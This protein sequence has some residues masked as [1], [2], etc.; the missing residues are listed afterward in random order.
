MAEETILEGKIE[1]KEKPK[2][3]FIELTNERILF[4][5]E[6]G[7]FKKRMMIFDELDLKKINKENKKAKITLEELKITIDAK[8]GLIEFNCKEEKIAKELVNN[9]HKL[10]DEPST[11]EK[12]KESIKNIVKT[13]NENPEY[14]EGL[15]YIIKGITKLFKG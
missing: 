1:R 12:G 3:A 6:K 8:D 11:F 4:K 2:K 10:V 15:V 14:Q 7:L 9:I 13:I 5:K